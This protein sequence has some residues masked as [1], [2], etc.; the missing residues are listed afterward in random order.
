MAKTLTP[1]ILE[2]QLVLAFL[3]ILVRAYLT[4]KVKI[5]YNLL[6]YKPES[7]N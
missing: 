6:I 7:V 4:Q 2:N 5:S 3:S 1:K